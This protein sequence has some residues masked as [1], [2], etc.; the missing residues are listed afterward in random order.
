MK[1]TKWNQAEIDFLTANYPQRGSKYCAS[2]LNRTKCTVNQTAWNLGLTFVGLLS[3]HPDY[4]VCR[5][6]LKDKP[7][8][9]FKLV[10]NKPH[11][12]CLDCLKII[13]NTSRNPLVDRAYYLNNAKTIKTRIYARAR[14]RYK[15]DPYF[16]MVNNLRSRI[17]L[18]L[19]N[20]KKSSSTAKLTGCPLP[21]LR[22][23]IASQFKTGMTWDNYG[24]WEID[25]IRPCAS[26]DLSLS[27]QQR[28]CFHFTNLQPLW[29]AENRAKSATYTKH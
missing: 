7:L 16:R 9:Q 6:C 28:E 27:E 3:A 2:H 20:N 26:F 25:H 29:A 5:K 19:K 10:K 8:T 1:H 21:D 22:N 24:Q 13:N 11:T 4:K 17:R 15:I 12:Y 18:A 14:E 23:H